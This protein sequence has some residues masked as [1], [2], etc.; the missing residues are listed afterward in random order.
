M[1]I[2]VSIYE[3]GHSFLRSNT[4][5]LRGGALLT[6]CTEHHNN[7][8]RVTE[9]ASDNDRTSQCTAVHL[10]V[11]LYIWGVVYN[12][13]QCSS[14]GGRGRMQAHTHIHVFL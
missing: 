11:Q 3:R 7:N 13:R 2:Q 8:E 14:D 9:S 4:L 10:S 6:D 1:I 5:V 12:L